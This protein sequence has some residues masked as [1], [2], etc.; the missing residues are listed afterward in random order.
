MLPSPDLIAFLATILRGAQLASQALAI[1]GVVFLLALARPLAGSLGEGHADMLAATRA[2]TR[3]AALLL[4][5]AALL[6]TAIGIVDVMSTL[7]LTIGQSLGA[8]FVGWGLF[9]TAAAAIAAVAAGGRRQPTRPLLL[10]LSALAALTASVMSSHAA[11][12]LDGRTFFLIA[13]FLHQGGAASWIGGIPFFLMAMAKLPAAADKTTVGMRFSHIAMISVGG[14][15][16]GAAMFACGYIGSLA[17]LE[18]TA[19]GAMTVAKAALLA[20][21]L[22]FGLVNF[23]SIRQSRGGDTARLAHVRRFCEAE[24]GIGMTVMFVAA[25]LATQPPAADQMADRTAIATI[26]EIVERM[27][28]QWP[29]LSSPSLDQISIPT[30][31][32]TAAD[33]Q[34][35]DRAWSEFNHHWAGLVVLAIGLLALAERTGGAGWARHWPLLFLL[36]AAM[37]FVRSDPESWPLGPI[38]FFQRLNDPEVMQHRLTVLVVAGFGLFEWSVRSGRWKSDRARLLFPLL[39]ALGGALLLTHSHSLTDVK[40]RYLIELTHIPMGILGILAGWARWLELRCDG[41]AARLA[42][43]IWPVCFALIGLLLIDYRES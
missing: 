39:C 20:V 8:T 40:Q 41:R 35:A 1:G 15:A 28:P 22:L 18:G 29:R 25:S 26:P 7:D 23:L 19:Y 13:G 30:N 24:I 17:A 10:T 33:S 27:A 12:R 2:W 11:A 3:R 4:T 32:A 42:S 38:P 16:V 21:L 31:I 9:M 34:E 43:W 36:L 14:L 37:L 6:S 5:A